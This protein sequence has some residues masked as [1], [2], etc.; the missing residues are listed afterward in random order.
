M[1]LSSTR[2]RRCKWWM[3]SACLSD[4]NRSSGKTNSFYLQQKPANSFTS[5]EVI[6]IL[7][8]WDWK[9]RCALPVTLQYQCRKLF[10][11]DSLGPSSLLSIVI[12]LVGA[13]YFPVTFFNV[14]NMFALLQILQHCPG[15]RVW[16]R[17]LW[18]HSHADIRGRLWP[19]LHTP[20]LVQLAHLDPV[21]YTH[22]TLPTIYSV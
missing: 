9:R 7:R 15:R 11:P 3:I 8:V 19:T 20:C 12:K 6:N 5:F 2:K 1:I 10:W 21:S 16:Q 4:V 18:P 14:I 13:C 17:T 22:L